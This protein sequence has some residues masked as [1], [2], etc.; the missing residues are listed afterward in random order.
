MDIRRM[1]VWRMASDFCTAEALVN[2]SHAVDIRRMYGGMASDF[3]LMV[4]Q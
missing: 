1:D 2:L 4:Q 3:L